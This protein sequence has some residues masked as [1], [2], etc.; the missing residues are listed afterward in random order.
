VG[1]AMNLKVGVNAL[2]GGGV[3]NTVK[4]LIFEKGGGA[5]LPPPQLLVA[6]PLAG[7]GCAVGL[8]TLL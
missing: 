8:K 5:S 2:E 4:A 6:P 3:V 7:G 1:G